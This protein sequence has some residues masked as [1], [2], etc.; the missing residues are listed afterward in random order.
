[1]SQT[2]VQ[3]LHSIFGFQKFRGLQQPIIDHLIHGG[4]AL[5]LMPTGGGKS[6]CYQIPALVRSG[7]GIVVSPLIALMED[8]V[9]ALLQMGVRAAYLNSAQSYPEQSQVKQRLVRGDID[10]LYV[11]PE[12]AVTEEFL[13]F[14]DS[15]PAIALIAIDE[16]H[17]VS[18]WG[19]DFRP[20]YQALAILHT[21][22]PSVPRV[23]LTATADAPTQRDIVKYLALEKA[24]VFSTGFDRPNIQYRIV[25]KDNWKQ[26]LLSFLRNEHQGDAG[27]IYCLTREKTERVA[28]LLQEQGF[29]AVPYHA[30]LESDIRARHQK[31]FIREEG[32]IVVATVAFGM[33]IDKP[34]VRFV[35]HLDLPKSIEAYY[36]ETGRAGRDGLPATAWMSYGLGE[37]VLLKQRLQTSEA[38]EAFKRTERQKLDAMIGLCETV[39]CRRQVLLNYFGEKRE[40]RCENCDTCLIPVETWDG[41]LAAQQALSCV[42]RTEQRFGVNYLIDV[43]CGEE[44]ERVRSFRHQHLSTFGIGRDRTKREWHSVFRQLIAFGYLSVDME[45]FGSLKLTEESLSVLKGTTAVKFRRDPE[46]ERKAFSKSSKRRTAVP[47]ELHPLWEAL[48]IKRVEIARAR[49]IPP[50]MIFHDSTLQEILHARPTTLSELSEISGVGSYKLSEFGTAFLEVIREHR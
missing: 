44:N 7:V 36:Q 4:D 45:G 38:P 24:L 29:K 12:R 25:L 49:N 1:M 19:H 50:Y 2:A 43:L 35:A 47:E 33:G 13:G 22:F 18:Q 5:V 48:R 15:L 28:I 34:N 8:Q 21:R 32:V 9:H 20:E 17:C 6:L 30:G 37:V 31:L 26:Q 10:L 42:Y 46:R 40:T 3:L 16:A 11:S 27:I 14:L 23:A 41:T 39:G